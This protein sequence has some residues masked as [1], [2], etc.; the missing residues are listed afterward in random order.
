VIAQEVNNTNV[1]DALPSNNRPGAIIEAPASIN[2]RVSV[3]GP[4]TSEQPSES[5]REGPVRQRLSIA[6]KIL[7]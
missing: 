7:G 5:L 4:S 6:V 2:F 1:R 3:S